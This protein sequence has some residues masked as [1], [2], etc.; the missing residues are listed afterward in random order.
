MTKGKLAIMSLAVLCWSLTLTGC[1]DAE[2]EKAIAEAKEAKAE[3]TKVKNALS[4]A[5]KQRDDLKSQLA[6]I[7]EARDKLQE[8][9]NEL[10]K[11]RGKAAEA[12]IET[13][14]QTIRLK[15]NDADAHY[16]LGVAYGELS[17]YQEAIEV[18]RQAVRIKPD[19]AE[20][21]VNLGAAYIKLGDQESARQQYE[22]L[23]TLNKEL[24][25]KLFDIR[26]VGLQQK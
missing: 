20:A 10:G 7:T 25:A 2:K 23:K 21:H 9:V 6:T 16:N 24:A 14:Q 12:K 4:T 1:K 8:Q 15:P 18:Y 17:R 11:A 5:E 3:L 13:L 19:Y 22:I 26:N